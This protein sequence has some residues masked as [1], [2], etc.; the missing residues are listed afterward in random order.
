MKFRKKSVFI[1]SSG[2]SWS[3]DFSLQILFFVLY[4]P[5]WVKKVNKINVKSY[6]QFNLVATRNPRFN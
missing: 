6:G 3:T 4:Q 5:S 2:I 1:M